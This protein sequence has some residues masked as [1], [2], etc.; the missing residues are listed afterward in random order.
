[1]YSHWG[2]RS[3]SSLK[4]GSLYFLHST[5][6]KCAGYEIAEKSTLKS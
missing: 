5:L 2:W 6:N 4:L 3:I 1:M